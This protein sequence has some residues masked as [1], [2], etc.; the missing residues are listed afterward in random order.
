MFCCSDGIVSFVFHQDKLTE[1]GSYF[2]EVTNI[3]STKSFLTIRLAE[4]K[5]LFWNKTDEVWLSNGCKVSTLTLLLFILYL[6]IG[7][8]PQRVETKQIS[9]GSSLFDCMCNNGDMG[10]VNIFCD[11]CFMEMCMII[12]VNKI[13]K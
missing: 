2:A 13:H 6:R 3:N 1:P 9:G 5:C 11:V 7:A 12:Y 10:P 4:M 8:G